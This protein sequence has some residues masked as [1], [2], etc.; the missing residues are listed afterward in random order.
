M[1]SIGRVWEY[2]NNK[3]TICYLKRTI[4]LSKYDHGNDKYVAFSHIRAT[5]NTKI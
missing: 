4:W 3:R 2:D 5:Q 1:K